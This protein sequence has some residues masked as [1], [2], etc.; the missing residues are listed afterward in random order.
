M[1]AFT[2]IEAHQPFRIAEAMD[3]EGVR[4]I[5]RLKVGFRVV[6][7]DGSEGL[8]LSIREAMQAAVRVAA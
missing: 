5:E 3:A 1:N 7:Q 6:M 2:P 8:G 4:I